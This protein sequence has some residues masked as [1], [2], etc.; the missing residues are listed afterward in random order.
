MIA[1]VC[2]D[3]PDEVIRTVAAE[4]LSPAQVAEATGA[5]SSCGC[6]VQHVERLVLETQAATPECANC[7]GCPRHPSAS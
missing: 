7:P 1:C 3:I 4:G 6:C 2:L 5:G